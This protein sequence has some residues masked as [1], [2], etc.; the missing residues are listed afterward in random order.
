MID[1]LVDLGLP[2]GLWWQDGAVIFDMIRASAR[3]AAQ[4]N[5][6]MPRFAKVVLALTEYNKE[7]GRCDCDPGREL[8]FYLVSSSG[9]QCD[10]SVSLSFQ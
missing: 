6:H 1:K 4:A 3:S 7:S 2:G 9:A 5:W 8:L 10:G